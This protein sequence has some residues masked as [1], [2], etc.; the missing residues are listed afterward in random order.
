MRGDQNIAA[1][2][3]LSGARMRWGAKERPTAAIGCGA[4]R[5]TALYLID[6]IKM[7]AAKAEPEQSRAEQSRAEQSRAE[8]HRANEGGSTQRS[9]KLMLKCAATRGV[10][11]HKWKRVFLTE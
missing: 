9:V 7:K 3:P 10:W 6:K 1:H 11:N 8:Q 5:R 2:T 4:E